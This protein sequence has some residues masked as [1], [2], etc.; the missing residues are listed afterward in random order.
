MRPENAQPPPVVC[1]GAAMGVCH[2]ARA[3]DVLLL[4]VG[5]VAAFIC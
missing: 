1:A 2:L 3:N 5:L 4:P